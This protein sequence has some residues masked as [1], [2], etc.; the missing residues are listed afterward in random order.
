MI[1]KMN[2]YNQFII[3]F[4]ESLMEESITTIIKF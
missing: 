4:N 2:G 1:K 3:Y